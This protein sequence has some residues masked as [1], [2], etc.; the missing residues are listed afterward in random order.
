M[1]SVPCRGVSVETGL[2]VLAGLT[3]LLGAQ[4][5][6]EAALNSVLWSTIYN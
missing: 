2:A 5:A 3:V 4:G 1:E 6:W